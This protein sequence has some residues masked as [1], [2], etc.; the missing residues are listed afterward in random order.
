MV[1][2]VPAD[3]WVCGIFVSPMIL[4][5][6]PAGKASGASPAMAGL[7]FSKLVYLVKKIGKICLPRRRSP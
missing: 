2:P 6:S 4:T 7:L 5:G 1:V 3:H